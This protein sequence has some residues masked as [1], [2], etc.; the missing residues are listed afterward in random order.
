MWATRASE[1]NLVAAVNRSPMR[2]CSAMFLNGLSIGPVART[3]SSSTA[4]GWRGRG[5]GRLGGLMNSPTWIWM[6]AIAGISLLSQ[7]A[8]AN[9][10]VHLSKSVWGCVDPNV[11]PTINDASNPERGDPTWL[12]RTSELGHCAFITPQSLWELLSPDHNGLTYLAY[13][14]TTGRLGSFWCQPRLSTFVP[15]HKL[16]LRQRQPSCRGSRHRR[17]SRLGRRRQAWCRRLPH[18]PRRRPPL[19]NRMP[20]SL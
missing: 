6:A 18:L 9:T 10:L 13:R 14:G 17:S 8:A 3:W 20:A 1:P 15:P 16:P 12:T 7:G 11:T 5:F 4:E 19:V 2:I